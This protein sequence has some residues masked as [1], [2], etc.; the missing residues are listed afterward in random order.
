VR[1]IARRN[2]VT[3]VPVPGDSPRKAP[4]LWRTTR[5]P[6]T[7]SLAACIQHAAAG[8]WHLQQRAEEAA[9]PGRSGA[10][11]VLLPLEC[12]AASIPAGGDPLRRCQTSPALSP[13]VSRSGSRAAPAGG[14]VRRCQVYW[15][16][17]HELVAALAAALAGLTSVSLL[18]PSLGSPSRRARA[19]VRRCGGC[20]AE[21]QRRD[22]RAA[23]S[24][25]RSAPWV[26]PCA[27]PVTVSRPVGFTARGRRLTC[28]SPAAPP[29]A[30]RWKP[31]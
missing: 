7:G 5:V 12:S 18:E 20:R 28:S 29:S 11:G 13:L 1:P 16:A 27:A 25:S 22:G 4:S 21:P 10:M 9:V 2:F 3:V 14:A 15:Q 31:T 6:W 8:R 30:G 26:E 23:R 24:A 17:V 19:A